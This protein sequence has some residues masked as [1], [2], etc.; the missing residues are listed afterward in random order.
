MFNQWPIKLNWCLFSFLFFNCMCFVAVPS[1]GLVTIINI[2]ENNNNNHHHHRHQTEYG[3]RG[4]VTQQNTSLERR[5]SIVCAEFPRSR[6]TGI[7]EK[8][9]IDPRF[10]SRIHSHAIRSN[11][12]GRFYHGFSI[13]VVCIAGVCH[14]VEQFRWQIGM[15]IIINI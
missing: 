11:V 7:G 8:F 14:C 4:R 10:G 6:H 5:Y 2:N 1:I 9:P 3:Q 12:R 13:S 15:R